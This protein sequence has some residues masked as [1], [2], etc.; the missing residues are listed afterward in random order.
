MILVGVCECGGGDLSVEETEDIAWMFWGD[1]HDDLLALHEAGTKYV[2]ACLGCG[3]YRL[4]AP[5]QR[6][7]VVG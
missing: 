7:V 6:V 3:Y 4:L 5:W 2:I 1:K